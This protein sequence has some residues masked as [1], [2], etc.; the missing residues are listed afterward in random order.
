MEVFRQRFRGFNPQAMQI[1]I[2]LVATLVVPDHRHPRNFLTHGHGHEANVI[3]CAP[4][5]AR[6]NVI[7]EAQVI[8]KIL[9]W[10]VKTCLG[11]GMVALENGE[12]L[13]LARSRKETIGNCGPEYVLF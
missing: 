11:S 4:I 1:E 3:D 13:A 6:F 12:A 8:P 7:R 10:E 9:P 2:I 5:L